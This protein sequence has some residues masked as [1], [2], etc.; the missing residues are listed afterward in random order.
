MKKLRISLYRL[1]IKVFGIPKTR[2]MLSFR[3]GSLIHSSNNN[4]FSGN[5]LSYVPDKYFDNLEKYKTQFYPFYDKADIAKWTKGNYVNN[6]GD[7]TRFYF[8]NLV[9]DELLDG[10][11]KGD[12]AELGV[13]KGNSAFLL[14]KYARAINKKLYLFDTFEGFSKKDIEGLDSKKKV[15]QFIDT[16]LE[17]VK[18]MVGTGNVEYIKGYF[19][20]SLGQINDAGSLKFSLVHVDCDLEKPFSHALEYFYPKLVKGGFLIMHDYSSLYWDG[21]RKA[22]KEF[23]IDKPESIIPIPDKSGT[24]ALRKM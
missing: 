1:R 13:Y 6:A 24:I 23:L 18:D 14:A 17:E 21:A 11:I 22:I 15:E 10:G 2:R 16:S 8:L 4:F 7:L 12:I 5:Y 3:I 20:E 9:I 19:P